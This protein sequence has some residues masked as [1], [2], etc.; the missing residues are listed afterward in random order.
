MRESAKS[1]RV[2]ETPTRWRNEL[3]N[4]TKHDAAKDY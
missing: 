2:I 1:A 4:A 3:E